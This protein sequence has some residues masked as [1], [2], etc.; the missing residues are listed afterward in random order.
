M[1]PW[2]RDLRLALR[3]LRL[4]PGCALFAIVSLALGIGVST[5]IYPAVRTLLWM[6]LSIVEPERAVVLRASVVTTLSPIDIGVFALV[7]LPFAAAALLARYAPAWHAS[8]VDPN[9]ALRDL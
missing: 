9:V 4:A 5:A 1:E 8:R 2:L 7:P 3:R 6:P